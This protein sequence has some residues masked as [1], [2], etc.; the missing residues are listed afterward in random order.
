MLGGLKDK[1]VRVLALRW[2]RGKAEA[3][4]KEGNPVL[5]F[6]DGNERKLWLLAFVV[7][8]LVKA[9]TGHDVTQL[10][11]GILAAGGWGSSSDAT[12]AADASVGLV[13]WLTALY[14]AGRG[15][16]DWYKQHKAGATVTELGSAPG[17]VKAAMADGSLLPIIQK[18]EIES[19]TKLVQAQG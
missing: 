15:L 7:V 6:I 12:W 14:A 10:M 1:I 16:W 13:T 18:A 3:G 11:N 4:R 5:K 8:G 17:V 19:E 9:L 2:I